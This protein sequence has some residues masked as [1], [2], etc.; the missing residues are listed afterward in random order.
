MNEEKRIENKKSD[1][2]ALKIFIPL[3][4]VSMIVGFASGYLGDIVEA[5]LA[6]VIAAGIVKG[7]VI[8]TPYANVV[9]N[10]VA[11]I[12]CA[13]LMADVKKCIKAWDGE[14]EEEYEK[15]DKKLSVTSVLINIVFILSYFFFGA[16]FEFVLKKEYFEV[17]NVICYFAGFI[18]ALTGNLLIQSKVVNL[19]KEM[20]PEKQGSVYA[21]DFSK[22]WEKSC[23][24]AERMQI[25]KAAFK[26]Y[27]FCNTFYI[28]LWLLCLLGNQVWHYGIMPATVVIIV[29]LANFISYQAYA[30][31]YAKNPNKI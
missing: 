14:N 11:I 10:V 4:I 16:G 18:V 19:Y 7:L 9:M 26:S 29:W 22:Q 8:I 1:K 30:A 15:I 6:D 31:Y 27:N 3:L 5:N 17:I 28:F 13:I 2:K 21:M 12:I 23:D 20:N 24:E 25:Y